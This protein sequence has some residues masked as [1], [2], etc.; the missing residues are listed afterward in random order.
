MLNASASASEGSSKIN[1]L[2]FMVGLGVGVSVLESVQILV[3]PQVILAAITSQLPSATPLFR[4]SAQRAG[5]HQYFT[6][7]HITASMENIMRE[8]Q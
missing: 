3:R 7:R 4:N 2:F 8:S 5:N 1:I 6:S